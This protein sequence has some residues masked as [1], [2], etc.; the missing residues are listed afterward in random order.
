MT[1]SELI[2]RLLENK[3]TPFYKSNYNIEEVIEMLKTTD[4]KENIEEIFFNTGLKTRTFVVAL[5]P[6]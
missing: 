6:F 4:I 1:K 2:E 5:V 3:D